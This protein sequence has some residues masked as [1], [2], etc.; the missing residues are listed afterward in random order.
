MLLII[1]V[2]SGTIKNSTESRL[3]LI[4]LVNIQ[5]HCNQNL[6]PFFHEPIKI[7]TQ[8]TYICPTGQATNSQQVTLGNM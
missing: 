1:H 4:E 8:N 7:D 6:T 2:Y 3:L 5:H